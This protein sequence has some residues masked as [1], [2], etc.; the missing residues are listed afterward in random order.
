MHDDPRACAF[1]SFLDRHAPDFRRIAGASRGEWKAGDIRNEAWL[2]AFDLGGSLGRPL[3]LDDPRDANLLIRHLYNHCVKYAERVVRHAV[4]LD[5]AASGD[6]DREQHWLNDRLAADGGAHPLSLLEL[7]ESDS[8]GRDVPDPY[9]SAAA[10]WAWLMARFDN[11]VAEVAGFLMISASWCYGCYGKARRDAESQ[12]PL[13]HGLASG[14][15]ETAIQPWRK[16]KL[17]DRGS[18]A[19]ANQL[20]LD[21]WAMPVQPACG[22]Q[23]LF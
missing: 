14:D 12:W 19:G 3:D 18:G 22:Q 2:L 15:D 13:P 16:F 4:R 17:P 21:Y 1:D 7:L 5:H 11:K 8:T 23:W 10:G 9:L 6:D 20:T